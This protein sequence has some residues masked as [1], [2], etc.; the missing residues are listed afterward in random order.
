MT[1][2]GD[3]SAILFK[4][5]H[6][7]GEIILLSV[8][9]YLTYKLSYRD[10]RAIL[11][12]RGINVAHTNILL[13]VWAPCEGP[14]LSS[15][16]KFPS[17]KNETLPCPAKNTSGILGVARAERWWRRHNLQPVDDDNVHHLH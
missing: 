9:W 15:T 17:N 12:E 2:L 7:D 1:H 3:T 4:R 10:L 8:R 5:R 6:A 13:E 11:A 14:S 16:S